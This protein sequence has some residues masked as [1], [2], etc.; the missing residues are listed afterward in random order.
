MKTA[1]VLAGGGSRGAYQIGVWQALREMEIPIH[2][3]TGTSVG[4]LNGALIAQDSFDTA[5]DVWE[6]IDTKMVFDLKKK[7]TLTEYAKEFFQKGGATADG[8]MSL[9]ETHLDEDAIRNS[10]I[11][12]GLVAVKKKGLTPCELYTEDIPQGKLNDYLLASAACYPAVKSHKIEDTEYIDGGYYDNMPVSL[13]LKKG[14]T[15]LIVVNLESVGMLQTSVK[16]LSQDKNTIYISPNHDLGNFLIFDKATTKRNIRL[17]YLD[18]LK[19][20]SF[21]SGSCFTFAKNEFSRLAKNKSVTLKKWKEFFRT[22]RLKGD[23]LA[24]S[25]LTAMEKYLKG[26]TSLPLV[27]PV[28]L[29]IAAET[30]GKLLELNPLTLYSFTTFHQTLK[31]TASA[32][33]PEKNI[34]ELYQSYQ[35]KKFNLKGDFFKKLDQKTILLFLAKLFSDSPEAVFRTAQLLPK[36]SVAALYLMVFDLVP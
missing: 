2:I 12:F 26:N 29:E 36:E 4:A 24:L 8:L 21:F 5:R 1:L 7:A 35:N 28:I 31:E 23:L 15:R 11:E 14:A 6:S 22:H 20:F 25:A 9:L 33:I 27:T 10:P 34:L 13:A 16:E 3:V 18:T 19:A 30:A 17:G 32:L